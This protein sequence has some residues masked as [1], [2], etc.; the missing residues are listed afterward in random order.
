M[1]SYL[2][3]PDECPEYYLYPDPYAD[4]DYYYELERDRALNTVMQEGER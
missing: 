3:N 2:P 4:D 1:D